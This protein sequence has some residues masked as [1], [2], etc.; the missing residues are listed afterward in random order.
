MTAINSDYNLL[1]ESKHPVLI[2]ADSKPVADAIKKIQEGK[3]STSSWMNR[4]LTNV[5]KLPIVAKHLSSKFKL[6]QVADL[7]SCYTPS[8]NVSNCSIHKFINEVTSTV[9]DLAA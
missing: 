1:R 8:C 7:L 9:I 4:L 5:N 2:L 3:F 6:N